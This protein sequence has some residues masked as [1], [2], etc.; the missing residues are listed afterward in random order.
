[1]LPA[2]EAP[3]M[4]RKLPP[5]PATPGRPPSEEGPRRQI[6]TL[7]GRAEFKQWLAEFAE[8]QR[9]DVASLLDDALE[10]WAAKKGFRRPPIR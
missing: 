9:T 7:R 1:M 6:L 10:A 4:S 8:E 5:P 2:I 3:E